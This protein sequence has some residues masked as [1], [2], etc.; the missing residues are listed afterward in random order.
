MESSL[1]AFRVAR[2]LTFAT[3]DPGE[4]RYDPYAQ[5]AVWSGSGKAI[6][7]LHCTN[8]GTRK[9]NA[10]GTYCTTFAGTGTKSYCDS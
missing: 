8:G 6:A 9:C 10:Y 7:A 1:F 5:T 3:E 2:P 4:F